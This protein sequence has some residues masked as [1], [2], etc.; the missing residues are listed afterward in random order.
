MTNKTKLTKQQ[1][2]AL[3]DIECPQEREAA[4][5]HFEMKNEFYGQD[6]Q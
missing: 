3:K 1:E 2:E 6:D 5:E 4:R